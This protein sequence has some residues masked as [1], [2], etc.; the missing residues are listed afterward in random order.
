[1]NIHTTDEL[2]KVLNSIHSTDDLQKFTESIKTE[3]IFPSFAEFLTYHL[4]SKNMSAS[5]LIHSA[6]IQRNY[7]YQIL[8]GT[9][10]PGRDKVLALCLALELS[11]DDIQRALTISGEAVLYPKNSRDSIFIFSI[12]HHLSVQQ[13]NELLFEMN[14]EPLH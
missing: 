12:S 7:G 14:Q 13:T 4:T 10:H 1:M 11:L 3:R 8:N 2:M 6:N 5:D 9:K